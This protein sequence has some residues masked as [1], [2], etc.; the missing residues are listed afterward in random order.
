M[1]TTIR[2]AE[3]ILGFLK[4]AKEIEGELWYS[5]S[6]IQ[7]KFQVLLVKNRQYLNDPENTQAHN[8]L[9]SEQCKALDDKSIEM[10]YEMAESIIDA[11]NYMGGPEMRG[12][13][14]MSPLVKLGL[15]YYK[16]STDKRK[17]IVCISDVGNKLLAGSLSFEEFMCDALFKYQYP[18]PSEAGFTTWNTK[19]FIN[20]LRL[21]KEV[22]DLCDSRGIKAKGIS[23]TEFGIFVLSLRRFDKVQDTAVELLRFRDLLN[24]KKESERNDFIEEY[25]NKYLK[26]FNNPINNCR[27]YTDNMIRY[28]RMTKYIYIRGKYEHTYVDLEPHRMTEINSILAADNGM[29]LEFTQDEWDVYMGTYGTYKLPFESIEKLTT[30]VSD[31]IADNK[32]LSKK[33]ELTYS[34]PEIPHTVEELKQLIADERERRTTLQNLSIKQDVHQNF[35]KIDETVEALTDIIQHNTASLTKRMS[36]ELEKWTNVALNIINDADLIKP[37]AA[38][39][40]DNE[41]LYTAPSGV[42]DIECYYKSFGSICEVTML[43]SRDQW[44]NEGQ[45]VMRHLRDFE[46]K[47]NQQ[48]N[49]CLFI[50]PSLHKD[51]V[52]TFYNA[53]KY[54]YE[55]KKQKI[56]PITIGQ[57]NLILQTVKSRLQSKQNFTHLQLQELMDTCIDIKHMGTSL[58]WIPYIQSSIESW[59]QKYSA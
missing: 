29:A 1:S 45:P 35:D 37:N 32:S 33:L 3:R 20:A 46:Q 55:G 50:A 10:S 51:T 11:K 28:M 36:I 43:K 31:V 9:N 2:E 44:Y 26:A 41:P 52:N 14:S 38:V 19:P 57:L 15:V 47:N 18:N 56:V 23:S 4:T 13:Q 59:S 34:A 25:I 12:R 27:E 21:I 16:K 53:V 49:Y 6:P 8:K 39:G 17:K 5:G 30:I 48:P 42:P 58:E 24:S 54:E 22:N 7:K 40:D